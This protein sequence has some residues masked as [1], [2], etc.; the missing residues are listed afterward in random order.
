MNADLMRLAAAI[1]AY[2]RVMA[3]HH[4]TVCGA[5]W[6]GGEEACRWCASRRRML[7]ATLC[8]LPVARGYGYATAADLEHLGIDPAADRAEDLR[9]WARDLRMAVD[10]GIVTATEADT[11]LRRAGRQGRRAA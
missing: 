10:A 7:S 4:C 9:V 8:E 3:R 11:A 1:R 5:A 6:D 2:D